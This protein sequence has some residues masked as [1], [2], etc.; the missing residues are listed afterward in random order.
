MVHLNLFGLYQTHDF[1]PSVSVRGSDQAF[2]PGLGSGKGPEK[3]EQGR[4]H[5]QET[6]K[7]RRHNEAMMWE[8]AHRRNY[9]IMEE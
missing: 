3:G 6:M 2:V 9:V 7:D 1:V 8:Q 5:H 4:S